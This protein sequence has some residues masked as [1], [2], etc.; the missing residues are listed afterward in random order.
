[1]KLTFSITNSQT[2]E[3]DKFVIEQAPS[4]VS[5]HIALKLLGYILYFDRKPQIEQDVG[6]HYR[7]DLFS[8]DEFHQ[9]VSLWI[10]CGNIAVKKIDK[11]ATK[12]GKSGEFVILRRTEFD[13]KNLSDRIQK[14][15]HPERVTII[16]FEDRF[17]DQVADLIEGTNEVEFTIYNTTLSL[18]IN[19]HD[20]MTLII[21]VQGQYSCKS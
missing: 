7:P 19:G 13:A 3:R 17:V 21:D 20:M 12:M 18:K 8:W 5:W 4:E 1:M 6:Q 9:N 10:D 16:S 15:K 2:S 14:I 11:V